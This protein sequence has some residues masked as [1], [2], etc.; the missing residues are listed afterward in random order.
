MYCSFISAAS[1]QP[2]M[3]MY[4]LLKLNW[5]YTYTPAAQWQM[6]AI[7]RNW[8]VLLLAAVYLHDPSCATSGGWTPLSRPLAG[9]LIL[10]PGLDHRWWYGCLDM[11]YIRCKWNKVISMEHVIVRVSTK[12]NGSIRTSVTVRQKSL[13]F[14]C[15][16]FRFFWTTVCF[17]SHVLNKILVAQNRRKNKWCKLPTSNQSLFACQSCSLALRMIILFSC[18]FFKCSV[19][20]TLV[21]DSQNAELCHF[22]P[23]F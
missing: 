5:V 3:Y 18:C 6:N 10:T 17:L 22:W 1:E 14:H 2:F 9:H 7:W 13:E 20:L 16:S 4:H 21:V 19:R 15:M 12:A 11:W 8:T 23:T